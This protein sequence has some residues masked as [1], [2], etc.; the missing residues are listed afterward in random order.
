M[1]AKGEAKEIIVTETQ[2]IPM[3]L[4]CKSLSNVNL[5]IKIAET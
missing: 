1:A 2:K 5:V 4:I 3:V